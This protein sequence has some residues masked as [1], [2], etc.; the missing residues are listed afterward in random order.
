MPDLIEPQQVTW[1]QVVDLARRIDGGQEGEEAPNSQTLARLVLQFHA[2]VV[3]GKARQGK[4][5]PPP[6]I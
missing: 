6:R 4:T 2:E 1:E 5:P 3:G